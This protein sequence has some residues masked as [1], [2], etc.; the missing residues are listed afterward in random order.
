M[1]TSIYTKTHTY[2]INTYTIN[3]AHTHALH[4]LMRTH[5]THSLLHTITHTEKHRHTLRHVHVIKLSLN[6]IYITQP[7][8][9]N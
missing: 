3:I 5:D 8:T 2:T 4:T 9:Q 1:Q 7:H 6:Y